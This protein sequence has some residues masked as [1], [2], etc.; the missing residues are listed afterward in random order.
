[1]FPED[2]RQ[3]WLN[4]QPFTL[5][6]SDKVLSFRHDGL[7]VNMENV[8]DMLNIST[9]LARRIDTLDRG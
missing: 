8:I 1:L 3:P 6:V 2:C 4:L 9:E 7:D 5:E